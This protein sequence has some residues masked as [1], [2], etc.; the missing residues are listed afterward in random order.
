MVEEGKMPPAM[1]DKLV[2]F[3]KM[4]YSEDAGYSVP[5]ESLIDALKCFDKIILKTDEKA[6]SKS[7]E[8]E[9][10]E[11]VYVEVDT[12]AK[13]HATDNKVTYSQA[14]QAILSAD[15]ELADRYAVGGAE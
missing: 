11:N 6:E 4:N 13:K 9:T 2:G 1:R 15:K 12:R 8:K 10:F 5:V 14:V 7:D 3:D